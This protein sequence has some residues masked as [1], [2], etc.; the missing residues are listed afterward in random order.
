MWN[1]NGV[2]DVI[3]V[4][5]V[6]DP[7]KEKT[8]RWEVWKVDW[9]HGEKKSVLLYI[10]PTQRAAEKLA[11]R[12]RADEDAPYYKPSIFGRRGGFRW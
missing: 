10:A 8:K 12:A 5:Q 6:L 3:W 9:D 4:S 7:E 11:E 2:I 1:G